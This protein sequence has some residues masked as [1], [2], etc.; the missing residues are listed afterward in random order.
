MMRFDWYQATFYDDIPPGVLLDKIAADLPGAH[1]IEHGRKGQNGYAKSA[2]L[3]DQEEHPLATMLYGG[4]GGAPPN[5][6]GTGPDAPS[7]VDTV[8]SLRLDHGV[9]RGDACQ[10]LEGADWS[11]IAGD[12]KRIIARN[13]MSGS[14]VV[15]DNPEEGPTYYAGAASS[16]VRARVYRKD[17]QLIALG[18]SPDE[19]PQPIVRVEAQIR[20]R[21][22]TRRSFAWMGP[23][24]YF[25]ASRWLRAVSRDLL[26][27]H[28]AS[29]V[30]Q[31]REPV[32][33]ENQVRW[34]RTQAHKALS[35]ILARHPGD[36]A[37]GKFLREQV[38]EGG[39]NS[40]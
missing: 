22:A 34:L 19:F 20:P 18:V 30:M 26:E 16:A 21:T 14:S 3:F 37:F 2:V 8:R 28:P 5:I 12:V 23:E 9:T 31:K 25:G 32:T 13:G 1:R 38:I 35:A 24:A 7:F 40:C 29:I 6:R 15:P 10:D 36:E 33:Y 39:V 11:E 4:N 17:L 27:H